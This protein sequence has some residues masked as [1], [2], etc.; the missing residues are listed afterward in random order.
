MSL[1]KSKYKAVLEMKDGEELRKSY[2]SISTAGYYFFHKLKLI[3]Y[4]VTSTIEDPS[5][6][7]R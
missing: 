6:T 2:D 1:D 5:R 7:V 4:F 3:M